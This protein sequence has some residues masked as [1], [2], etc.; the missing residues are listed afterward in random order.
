[1]SIYNSAIAMN[2]NTELDLLS[3]ITIQTIV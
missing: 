2:W 3:A 1:M